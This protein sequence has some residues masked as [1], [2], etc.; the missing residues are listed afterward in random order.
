MTVRGQLS[1]PQVIYRLI[2]ITEGFGGCQLVKVWVCVVTALL[3]CHS[4][5]TPFACLKCTVPWLRSHY[6]H[7]FRTFSC[8]SPARETPFPSD[9]I[10]SAASNCPSFSFMCAL[11]ICFASRWDLGGKKRNILS[12]VK[13]KVQCRYSYQVQRVVC[14]LP[15]KY[16]FIKWAVVFLNKRFIYFYF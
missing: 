12:I 15:N 4:H 10:L 13:H 8:S 11:H 6:R 9:I 3:R 14:V 2:N 5:T 16:A 1:L 7:H